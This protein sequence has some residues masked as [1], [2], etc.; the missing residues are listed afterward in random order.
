LSYLF[1]DHYS[2]Q[3]RSTSSVTAHDWMI[4]FWLGSNCLSYSR[5]KP[6]PPVV[7]R[8]LATGGGTGWVHSIRFKI[9][10]EYF[11]FHSSLS[12]SNFPSRVT[13]FIVLN[14]LFKCSYL[15]YRPWLNNFF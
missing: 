9:F 1:S 11:Y 15:N 12:Y 14:V 5:H 4:W 3:E 10:L 8:L 13:I 6:V 7:G 2:A